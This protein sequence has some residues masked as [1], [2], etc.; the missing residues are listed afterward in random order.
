MY[1]RL[2]S[3]L[4]VAEDCE[5]LT[6]TPDTPMCWDHRNVLACQLYSVLA[7]KLRALCV[8]GKHSIN[9]APSPDCLCDFWNTV[10]PVSQNWPQIHCIAKA[11][12]DL[13][14]SVFLPQLP[15][16]RWEACT[17]PSGRYLH[18]STCFLKNKKWYCQ[19]T[20]ES[21]LLYYSQYFCNQRVLFIS[22]NF[23]VLLVS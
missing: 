20:S 11:K 12:G 7:I 1:P 4:W 17:T 13:L 23:T 16:L 15:V 8:S 10:S 9:W 19:I 22:S 14:L 5:Q 18:F 6:D 2:D 21:Y 3:T